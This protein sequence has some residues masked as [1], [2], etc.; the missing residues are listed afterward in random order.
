MK[1]FLQASLPLSFSEE[2]MK[3]LGMR[4]TLPEVTLPF[5]GYRKKVP[6]YRLIR[7]EGEGNYTRLHF[8]DRTTLVVSLTL[9]KLQA[10]LSPEIFVR[11]H[12]K[13]IVNLLYIEEIIHAD[14]L[15][16]RL[17]NGDEIEVSRRKTA[18][19]LNQYRA[20]QHEFMQQEELAL[21]A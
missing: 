13:N 2:Q 14:G 20:F 4:L 7:L 6:A 21:Q 12:K 9:K 5:W 1:P 18:K 15:I 10:R 16:L 19:F 3:V 11:P 17:S 8:D